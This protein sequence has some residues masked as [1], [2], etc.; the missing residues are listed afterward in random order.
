MKSI[1]L[2]VFALFI[3]GTLSAQNFEFGLNAGEGLNTVP[4][5][6]TTPANETSLSRSAATSAFSIKAMYVLPHWQIG[7]SAERIN[8]SYRFMYPLPPVVNNGIYPDEGGYFNSENKIQIAAPAIPLKLFLNRVITCYNFEAYFGL[9][10]GYVF[11]PD[12]RWGENAPG[13]SM[14]ALSS[15]GDGPLAG[16]QVGA[17]VFVT[18]HLGINAELS[19]DYISFNEGATNIKLAAF[20]STLGVRY[21][22]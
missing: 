14:V 7:I 2:S 15:Y 11:S 4:L 12:L 5:F 22:F 13:T 16:A 6:H 19:G 18:K 20:Q 10:L 21:K 8:L 17:T 1:F 3:A 9:N